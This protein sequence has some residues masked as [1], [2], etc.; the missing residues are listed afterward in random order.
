MERQ[1]NTRKRKCKFEMENTAISCAPYSNILKRRWF[2]L[3][4]KLAIAWYP[5]PEEL[6]NQ[7]SEI[8]CKCHDLNKFLLINFSS[9]HSVINSISNVLLFNWWNL[10]NIVWMKSC[11]IIHFKMHLLEFSFLLIFYRIKYNAVPYI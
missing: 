9:N 8:I 6:L 3:H 5:N 7:R 4:E 2:C 10:F 1:I 11:I